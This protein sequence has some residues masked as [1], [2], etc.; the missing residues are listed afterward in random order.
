MP[1]ETDGKSTQDTATQDEWT[2]PTRE[3][4]EKTQK[5]IKNKTE[6]ADRLHK[7]LASASEAE[8]KKAEDE[9]KKRGEFESLYNATKA[10]LDSHKAFRQSVEKRWEDEY[11]GIVKDWS[12][13]DKSLIDPTLTVDKRLDIARKLSKRFAEASQ[14]TERKP[15]APTAP[16]GTRG[17][18]AKPV[19]EMTKEEFDAHIASQLP[20]VQ[21]AT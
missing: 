2:P 1:D 7:K 21:I 9:A 6:E 8:A 13:E 16:A 14:T 10:E 17:G 15:G 4:W 20:K 19:R 3:E 12:D 5:T 18:P 11:D